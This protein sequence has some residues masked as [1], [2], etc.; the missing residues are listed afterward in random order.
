MLKF[1]AGVELVLLR[2]AWKDRKLYAIGEPERKVVSTWHM[3]KHH[4][5]AGDESWEDGEYIPYIPDVLRQDSL[6][7]VTIPVDISGIQ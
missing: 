5:T 6:P 1:G 3:I 7:T 2:H 4:E